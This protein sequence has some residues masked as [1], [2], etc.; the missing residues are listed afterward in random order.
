MEQAALK[1]R[2]VPLDSL[3]LDPANA[4][5][6]PQEN[7]EAIVASLRRFGQAEPLVIQKKTGRVIGGNGRLV[8]MKQLG[9]TECDVV[10]IDVDDIT[11]TALGIA[12]NRTSE[13]AAWDEPALAKILQELQAEDALEGV[14][15]S[16]EDIDA[17]LAELEAETTPADVDDHGPEVPPANPVSKVGDLWLLG[18]HRLLCGDSTSAEDLARVMADEKAALLST[19]P[20]YCV[21]YTGDNRPI[22]D[23]KRSGKDWSHVY[24]EID[25]K[26]LGTFL[27]SVFRAVLPHAIDTAPIYVWHAHVQQH[28]LAQVFD[29]FDILFHQVIVWVKPTGVFGHSYYQWRHEP[30]AFGWRRGHKPVHGQAQLNTVWEEDWDGKQRI[31]SFHPTSKPTRLFEIPMEQHTKAGAVVL[32]PFCGSGSQIIAAEKLGRKCRAMEISPAFVDGTILRWQKATNKK[33]LLE[34]TTKTFEQVGA[35]RLKAVTL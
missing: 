13:L 6:H 19:D 1:V 3:H 29:R 25:I 14:G 23:G 5:S 7:M 30:C 26:D 4:R 2:R 15:Y 17:L 24:R 8:A 10:E 27:D 21:D 16:T 12:L 32:E 35:E 31:T 28:V 11:A 33:A 34:G 9:W 18:N 20:P 22:H